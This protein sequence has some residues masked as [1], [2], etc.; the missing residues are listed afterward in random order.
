M[1]ASTIKHF[2]ADASKSLVRNKTLSIASIATVATTLFI[3][4]IF[5]LVV[6]NVDQGINKLGSQFEVKVYMDED[7]TITD[8][9]A[10]AVKINKMEGIA[11]VKEETKA[12]A[13][14]RF[15]EMVGDDEKYKNVI[16]DFKTNNP[17]PESYII[18]VEKPENVD[19]VL[20]ELTEQAGVS[21]IVSAKDTVEKVV[22]ITNSIKWAGLAIFILL[23]FVSLFLIMNTI[24]LTVFSRKR[25]IGI[26]KYV[27]ATDWFIR[28][29]F[30]IEG[31]IIGLLGSLIASGI[32]Y[33]VYKLIVTK[34]SNNF[35]MF[36]M[37][38]P[39]YIIKTLLWQFTLGGIV[40]G[41]FGSIISVRKFLKV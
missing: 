29:P 1:R 15:K 39:M 32:L 35:L 18:R 10:L 25:E 27:G 7:I 36:T 26:M 24:K 2:T 33:Y 12:D 17:L 6:F 22:N 3:L 31:I 14:E 13:L 34:M 20:N 4:G 40:I 8:K 38:E 37:I 16:E 19:K 5:L 30:I 11:E 23:F 21:D 41:I 9:K 28:W